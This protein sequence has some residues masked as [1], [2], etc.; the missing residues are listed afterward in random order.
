MKATEILA[1]RI[2]INSS[3]FGCENYPIV[4]FEINEGCFLKLWYDSHYN[5]ESHLYGVVFSISET[6]KML[7]GGEVTDSPNAGFRATTTYRLI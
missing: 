4:D 3:V 6:T 5:D 2:E 1:K 7:G